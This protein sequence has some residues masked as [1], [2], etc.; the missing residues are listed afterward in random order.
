MEVVKMKKMAL[1]LIVLGVV[2]TALCS[3]AAAAIEVEGDAYVGI[4]DKYLW[5]GF[6]LS[7]S[8]PVSQGGI[9]LSAGGFTLSYWSSV[10][11]S[12]NDDEGFTAGEMT[13]TDITL[14]YSFD[15][16]ELVSVSAGNIFYMVEEDWPNTHE[17]Y[18]SVGLNTILEPSAAVYY[19]WDESEEDGLFYTFS[20]GHTFEINDK[21]SVALGGLVSYNQ[22]SDFNIGDY[23]DWHNLELSVGADYA[24]TDQITLSPSFLYSEPLSDD[25]EDIAELDDETVVGLTVTFAF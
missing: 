11:L 3:P 17:L 1:V 13:E 16:G 4:F 14:D 22:E 9:N 21:F 2:L 15:I 18:L 8:E 23:S 5:R 25:A 12:S 19:D 7:A 6:D 10:Q 24:L 20:V